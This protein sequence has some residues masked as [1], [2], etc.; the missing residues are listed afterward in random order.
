MLGLLL[1]SVFRS[2]WR[3]LRLFILCFSKSRS[4]SEA[5]NFFR[6]LSAFRM[7]ACHA[8]LLF[9]TDLNADCWLSD[10]VI[11]VLIYLTSG[12]RHQTVYLSIRLFSSGDEVQAY[13]RRINEE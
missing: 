7:V 13:K 10:F 2:G 11:L 5:I 4:C 6:I 9:L 3:L 8:F 12:F 1:Y